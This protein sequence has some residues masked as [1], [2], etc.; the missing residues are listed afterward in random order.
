MPR[1]LGSVAYDVKAASYS[2]FAVTQTALSPLDSWLDNNVSN[3]DMSIVD[4]S[5]VGFVLVLF[6]PTKFPKDKKIIAVTFSFLGKP[7]KQAKGIIQ[8]RK[9]K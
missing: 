6:L 7:S 2:D 5:N 9:E 8:W 1:H 4:A 3:H